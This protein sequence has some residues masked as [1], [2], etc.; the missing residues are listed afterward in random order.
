MGKWVNLRGTSYSSPN[1]VST[2][3]WK[4]NGGWRWHITCNE[5]Q[6]M[7]KIISVRTPYGKRPLIWPDSQWDP[8]SSIYTKES[9]EKL[10]TYPL[11]CKQFMVGKACLVTVTLKQRD[12]NAT[13]K[14][15]LL[16]GFTDAN[17]CYNHFWYFLTSHVRSAA[18]LLLLTEWNYE[19]RHNVPTKFRKYRLTGSKI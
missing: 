16:N 11:L 8:M 3:T 12:P 10:N 2:V 5:K 19:V 17:I 7:Q 18:M 6:K 4:K 15:F 9:L 13:Q 1:I 14:V